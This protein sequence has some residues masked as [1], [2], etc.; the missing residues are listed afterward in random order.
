[1]SDMT[2]T[3][4]HV[5]RNIVDAYELTA[6]E[7]AAFDYLP[8][9]AIDSGSDGASFFR[10]RGELHDLGE[11]ETTSRLPRF[12]PLAR[13]DGYRADSF[14]SALV[15]RYTDDMEQVIVGLALS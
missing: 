12:S 2:I 13:W 7:R 11:F 14:Y 8:W 10:Y 1:M 6:D 9:D 3:T 5:P 15:V 4:N